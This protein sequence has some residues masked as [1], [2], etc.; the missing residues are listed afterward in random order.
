MLEIGSNNYE[1]RHVKNKKNQ[2]IIDR[3]IKWGKQHI[4]NFKR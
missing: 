1:E 2:R 4:S 3:Y